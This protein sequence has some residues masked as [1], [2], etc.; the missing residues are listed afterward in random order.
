MKFGVLQFFSWP[1]RRT[2]L[3]SVYQRALQRI[4]IMDRTG[5]DAVWLA[6]HHFSSFSVCPSVHMMGALVAART[7]RLRIGTGVSLAPFY[8]P[9]RLAEEVAFLDVLSGGRVNWGAGR[10][11]ARVEFE[12]FGVPPDE[13]TARF[14]ETV[15]IV[16]KAWTE[17]RLHFSGKYFNFDGVEVLPKP[18]Q[19]PHPPVWMAATSEAAIDWAARRGFS[20]LMDPHAAHADIGRKRRL[21]ASRLQAAGFTPVGRDLP[22]AR[23]LALGETATRAAEVA[24]RG[25]QWIVDSYFGSQHRPVGVAD[26]NSPGDDPVQR[27][28]D[29]VIIHGTPDSVLDQILRLREEIGLGYLLCAPLS[30]E[31][32]TLLT[33][34]ILPRLL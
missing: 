11:F 9:L 20:I 14:H 2:D 31:T 10:G 5:F 7:T 1:E 27:Y 33:E 6:E 4:E 22:V 30:H 19:H 15:D 24:R 28:L 29:Q 8:H 26:P 21:Y 18:L 13:S 23:L 32:F 3:A 16:L 25:A 12:N 17:E 34:Q